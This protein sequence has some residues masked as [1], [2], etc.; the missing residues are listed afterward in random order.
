MQLLYCPFS[1][2]FFHFHILL[3]LYSHFAVIVFA[4]CCCNK[5]KFADDCGA[6]ENRLTDKRDA[7]MKDYFG[8]NKDNFLILLHRQ[9]W[10]VN[11]VCM[12]VCVYVYHPILI[13]L[14]EYLFYLSKTNP[15]ENRHGWVILGCSGRCKRWNFTEFRPV[16]RIPP[17][18]FIRF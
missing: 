13:K 14:S 6:V 4:F 11:H 17:S 12:Y 16:N 2:Y 1:R 5:S 7:G 15:I 8:G 9:R 10:R 18:I 3:L